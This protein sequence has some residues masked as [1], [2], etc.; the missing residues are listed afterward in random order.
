MEESIKH[1]LNS[2][3]FKLKI[4]VIKAIFHYNYARR[5]YMSITDNATKTFMEVALVFYF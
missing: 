4:N 1:S 2:N 5:K 3:D